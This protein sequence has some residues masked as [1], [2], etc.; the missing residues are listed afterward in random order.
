MKCFAFISRWKILIHCRRKFKGNVLM[1]LTITS[2]GW[3]H[4]GENF[5]LKLEKSTLYIKIQS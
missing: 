2:S 1:L 3:L 4:M 5:W